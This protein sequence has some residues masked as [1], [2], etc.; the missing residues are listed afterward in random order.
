M[1]YTNPSM[2]ECRYVHVSGVSSKKNTRE[3][4]LHANRTHA[5]EF[6]VKTKQKIKD[7]NNQVT[8]LDK[9][10]RINLGEAF[11]IHPS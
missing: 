7:G 2:E 11:N 4:V 10:K 3:T 8:K 1:R 6:Y 9:W 5:S